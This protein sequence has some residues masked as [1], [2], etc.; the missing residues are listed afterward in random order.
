VGEAAGGGEALAQVV[1]LD[2]DLVVMDVQMP[3]V[4]GIG[5]VRAI[6]GAGR[7]V[8]IVMLTI[9]D[10]DDD[11][12]EAI[13]AGANGSLLKNMRPGRSSTDR[14][15]LTAS[16][17]AGAVAAGST[18]PS[19]TVARHRVVPADA[20]AGEGLD[21]SRD[22]DPQLISACPQQGDRDD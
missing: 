14:R 18:G 22:G 10:D 13:E 5:G 20:T 4:D 12:F 9:S 2:P 1:G 21:P 11:L 6:R 15:A 19:A 17:I 3:G 16:P 8:P 7:A